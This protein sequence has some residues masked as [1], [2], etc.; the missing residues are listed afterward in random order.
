MTNTEETTVMLL[1]QAIEK[2]SGI[3]LHTPSDYERLSS[4]IFDQQ[5]I[6]VSSSTLKRLWGYAGQEA[7]PRAFTL[8]VLARFVGYKD[9]GS[10]TESMGRGQQQQSQ[11]FLANTLTADRLAVG[12]RLQLTWHPDRLCIV[13][14]LGCGQFRVTEAQNTKLSVGDTFECHL[15]I[16]HEPLF[17]D[18]LIHNGLPPM[19]Y[20]AGRMDGIV[21]KKL[22]TDDWY[23]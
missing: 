5:H 15:F 2:V 4:V 11:L 19:S 6:T 7:H 18:R 14:H 9:Y 21:A 12:D 22:Q 17:I 16:N 3:T 1:C 23:S 10:F 8:D 13:E 20:V